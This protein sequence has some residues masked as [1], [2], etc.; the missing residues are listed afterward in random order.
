MNQPNQLKRFDTKVQYLKYKVLRETARMAWADKLLE[1]MMD[2]PKIIVPGKEP[3]MRCCVYKERAILAERV[4]MA[5]G[6]HAERGIGNGTARYTPFR[7]SLRDPRHPPLLPAPSVR[8]RR[9]VPFAARGRALPAA[10]VWKF[11]AAREV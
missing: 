5:M 11:H 4:K 7:K 2:I 6:G 8:Q 3:T 9:P 1:G 10:R